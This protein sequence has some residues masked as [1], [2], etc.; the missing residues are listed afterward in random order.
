MSVDNHSTS[1]TRT[2]SPRSQKMAL[3]FGVGLLL[4]SL[5]LPSAFAQRTTKTLDFPGSVNTVAKHIDAS[6]AFKVDC[7][8]NGSINAELAMLTNTGMTRGVTILVSGTCNENVL[9]QGFDRLSLVTAGLGTS[10][11]DPSQ[12]TKTTVDIEDSQNVTVQGF[13]INGGSEGVGCGGQS[14]CYLTGNTIQSSLSQGVFVVSASNAVLTRNVVQNNGEQGLLVNLNSS[15]SSNY[16]TFQGNKSSGIFVNQGYVFAFASTV[17]NNGGDGNAVVAANNHSA[18][19]LVSCTISGNLDAGVGVQGGSEASFNQTTVTGN[20]LDGVIVQDLSF[21][22]FR[23][24]IIT[25]NLSGVDVN[26]QPQF[27]ATRGALTDIGGGKTNC[28]EP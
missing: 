25:G 22:L 23:A 3:L 19:R 15:A 5:T 10:I 27:P 7:N 8:K 4:F 26:C 13:T 1:S 17:Q 14:L 28:T 6:S 16:D 24:S 18:I 21:A 2:A 20:A 9:I 12:G 11:N